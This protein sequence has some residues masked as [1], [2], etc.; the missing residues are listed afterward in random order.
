MTEETNTTLCHKGITTYDR[1]LLHSMHN[2]RG[3]GPRGLYPAREPTRV[4]EVNGHSRVPNTKNSPSE[5]R[6]KALKR[7]KKKSILRE[8]VNP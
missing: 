6:K 1:R 2:Y 4:T 5:I 3:Y 8:H 7:K